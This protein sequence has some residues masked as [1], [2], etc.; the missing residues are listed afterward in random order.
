MPRAMRESPVLDFIYYGVMFAA[1]LA[2]THA[3]YV[4]NGLI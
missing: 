3:L 1:A 4:A 2:L